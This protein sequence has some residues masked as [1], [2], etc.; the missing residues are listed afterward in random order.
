MGVL[1]TIRRWRPW[2]GR[3]KLEAV[4]F[5]ELQNRCAEDPEGVHREFI[6]RLHKLVFYAAAEYL[7]RHGN[8]DQREVEEMTMR[9]FEDFAPEFASGEPIRLLV[10]FSHAIRRV[11]DRE[12]FEGIVHL[13]YPLLP[14]YHIPDDAER[15]FLAAAYQAVLAGDGERDIDEILAERFETTV[16]EAGSILASARKHLD[17]VIRDDFEAAELKEATEGY[18][19]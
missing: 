9:V 12:A 5:E 16:E 18:L 3:P 8:R 14:T 13:Y 6:R 15:R 1:E 2:K 10:R 19:S 11:L 17:E 7:K 4:P